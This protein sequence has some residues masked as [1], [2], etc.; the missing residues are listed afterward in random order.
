MKRYVLPVVA[1]A[2]AAL[3]AA[4]GA[5]ARAHHHSAKTHHH[6]RTKA[7]HHARAQHAKRAKRRTRP[8]THSLVPSFAPHPRAWL[9]ELSEFPRN[10][11]PP[12]TAK[13]VH[14]AKP[15]HNAKPPQP[16]VAKP[17]PH[18]L[19]SAQRTRSSGW[20]QANS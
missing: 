16:Q 1:A 12:H 5:L 18:A 10:P 6:A 3:V 11:K 2:A 8:V 19:K 17:Q 15:A 7:R 20:T 9:K 14:R 13:P 4:N